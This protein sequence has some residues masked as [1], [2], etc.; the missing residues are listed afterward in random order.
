M[1]KKYFQQFVDFHEG[2][3]NKIIHLVGFALLGLAIIEKS[4]LLVFVG[5][6]TQELGHIYQ[7]A[8]TKKQSVNPLHGLKGQSLF[9]LPFFVL[10]VL[11]VLLA[12]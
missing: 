8:K 3:V 5:G 7:Y 6:L 11:Y 12:K 1:F 10:I 2:T 4:L 9:A